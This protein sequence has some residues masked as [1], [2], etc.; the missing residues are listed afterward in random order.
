[1]A[2]P[3]GAG[4]PPAGQACWRPLQNPGGQLGRVINIPAASAPAGPVALRLGRAGQGGRR[5]RLTRSGGGSSSPPPARCPPPLPLQFLSFLFLMKADELAKEIPTNPDAS[6]GLAEALP[7]PTIH[8][9][10]VSNWQATRPRPPPDG[11]V[12]L[13]L[14]PATPPSGPLASL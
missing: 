11:Q 1:M 8:I 2:T 10:L 5:A 13:P 12:L 9:S 6:L 7:K 4:N 3:E 14:C